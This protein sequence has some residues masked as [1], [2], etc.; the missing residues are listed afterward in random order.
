LLTE[1]L[2]PHQRGAIRAV[3]SDMHRPYLN[4][5]A[6]VLPKAY[7]DEQLDRLWTYKTPPGVGTFLIGWLEALRWQ[8]LPE[9]ERLGDFLALPPIAS[10]PC[11]SASWNP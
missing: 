6:E 5:V 7:S 8:R 2:D 3:C 1:D 11:G 10:I 4:A 9:M